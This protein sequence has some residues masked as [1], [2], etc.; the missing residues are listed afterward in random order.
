[1]IFATK[2]SAF[3]VRKEVRYMGGLI[4][5]IVMIALGAIG[6]KYGITAVLFGLSAIMIALGIKGRAE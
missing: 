2:T 3:M 1:M 5:G 4:L 6:I